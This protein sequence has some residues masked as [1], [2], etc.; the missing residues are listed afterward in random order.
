[1][2]LRFILLLAAPAAHAQSLSS[3][4]W[5]PIVG[6]PQPEGYAAPAVADGVA[7]AFVYGSPTDSSSGFAMRTRYGLGELGGTRAAAPNKLDHSRRSSPPPL[8]FATPFCGTRHPS[9]FSSY[10]HPLPTPP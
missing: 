7:G 2:L 5:T 4:Y 3:V 9:P 1:M 10:L 8:L 6:A